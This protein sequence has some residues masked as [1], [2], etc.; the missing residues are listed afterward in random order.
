MGCDVDL[1]LLLPLLWMVCVQHLGKR[2]YLIYSF[3]GEMDEHC[4]E[5]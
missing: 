2:L 4:L 5:K 3:E 1:A